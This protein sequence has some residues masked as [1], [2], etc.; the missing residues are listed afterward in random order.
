MRTNQKHS[1]INR[2]RI[3]RITIK[4]LVK[5]NKLSHKSHI[6]ICYLSSFSDKIQT[7]IKGCFVCENHVSEA[8]GGASGN[9]LDTVDKNSSALFFGGVEK[10]N[11]VIKAALDIFSS[12]VF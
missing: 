8:H 12:V 5:P 10:I 6:W 4:S 7:V 11:H 3:N 9:T 2:N 1:R